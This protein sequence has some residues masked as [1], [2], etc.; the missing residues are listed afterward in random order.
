MKIKPGIGIGPIK[1]G[2]SEHELITILGFP[3]K[4]EE[5]EHVK[6]SGDWHRCLWYFPQNLYFTFDKEDGY[7]LGTI[8]IMGSGYKLFEKELFNATKSLVRKSISTHTN[9]WLSVEDF[10]IIEGEP[11]ECM[12]SDKLGIIFWFDS[13]NLSE[14]QCSYL[15]EPDGNT[16]IWP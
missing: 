7:R 12:G 4:I 14:M 16:I 10:T 1:Y 11:H 8:T 6:D 15:F 3:D 9:E 13:N 5:E 2:I